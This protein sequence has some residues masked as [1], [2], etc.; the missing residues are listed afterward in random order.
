LE[1]NRKLAS[2]FKMQ[3]MSATLKFP[4]TNQEL[5]AIAGGDI[6]RFPASL[7]EFWELLEEAEYNVEYLNQEIIA[8]MSYE[9]DVHTDLATQ[10]SHLLK[11]VFQ[12]DKRF[13]VRNG[14]RPVC[15]P[16]CAF[17]VFN[18]DGSV[19]GMPAKHFEFR[20]GM[21]AELT[22]VLVFEVLSKST[23]SHDLADKLPCYKKIPTLRQIIFLDS[24]RLDV[25]IWERQVSDGKWVETNLNHPDG[26]F[27]VSKQPITLREIYED[28]SL[29]S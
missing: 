10:M 6:V 29:L 26:H 9:T 17:A 3:T 5:H 21:N 25:T 18:P 19:I 24:Q 12:T 15:I 2:L 23:R 16:E 8:S 13:R 7:E 22:P 1:K 4:V 27:L 28:T 11:S 14:N 20:P